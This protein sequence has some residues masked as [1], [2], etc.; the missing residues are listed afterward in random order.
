M[1]IN[2][3]SWPDV[4]LTSSDENAKRIHEKDWSD[5]PLGPIEKWSQSFVTILTT[6]MSSQFPALMLWGPD[7]ITFYNAGYATVLGEKQL[8]ALGKPLKEVWPE[9]WES[10]YGMLKGVIATGIGSW[11]ED[12]IY[13]LHRNGFSEESYFTFSFARIIDE[14]G[15][16]GGILCT[17]IETT[18][19]V[20][21]E[22]R[23]K[24]LREIGNQAGAKPTVEEVY[25]ESLSVIKQQTRDIPFAVLMI[26]SAD[27]LTAN[28]CCSSGLENPNQNI[29]FSE[30]NS[31]NIFKQVCK[32]ARSQFLAQLPSDIKQL[33]SGYELDPVSS[34]LV[35]PIKTSSGVVGL[36]LV[37]LSS[38]LP[39][40][41]SYRSFLDLV[42]G[43][44]SSAVASAKVQ[45]DARDR[46]KALAELDQLK[47]TFFSN[48]SHEFRT[49][50]TLILGPLEDLLAQTKGTEISIGRETFESIYRNS[51]RL[52]KLV[53]SL[54]DFSRMEA[55][56]VEASFE[57]VNLA[58]FTRDLAS[59]FTSVMQKGNL[60]LK[61]NSEVL[62]ESIFIDVEMWEK[63][64]LNLLSNAF[65]FTFQ[66]SVQ[67]FLKNLPDGVELS[68][69]DSGIGISKEELPKIF[70]RYHRVEGAK[71]RSF[72]GSG[73]GLAIVQEMV[74]VHRGKIM[75]ESTEGKGT[76]FRVFIPKGYA[77]LPLDQIKVER[78]SESTRLKADAFIDEASRWVPEPVII[79]IPSETRST[80]LIVDDNADMREYLSHMLDQNYNVIV[81][82]NGREA[83]NVVKSRRP[84]LVIS[85]IMMPEMDGF[86][87]LR[88]LKRKK[89]TNSLPV[90]FLSARAGNEAT[91]EGLEAGADDYLV[92]PFSS[93]ELIARVQ[94]QLSMVKLRSDLEHER[95]A[96]VARDEFL[97]IA[98]H[99]LN[100]P[101]T[102]LKLQVQS[103][104]RALE[105]NDLSA[106]APEKMKNIVNLLNRQID[107][108]SKLIRN[109]LDVTHISQGTMLLHKQKTDLNMIISQ[110]FEE[111]NNEITDSGCAV[112]LDLK[113]NIPLNMDAVRIQQVITNLLTNALKYAGGK[114]VRISSF[115][116]DNTA[117]L[118]VEDNGPGISKENLEII[119]NR[120]ERINASSNLGG[121]GLG[122][123]ISKQIVESHGGELKVESILGKGSKFLIGLPI[124]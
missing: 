110:V 87:L 36:L 122:L 41:E 2:K 57:P 73:I 17:A 106:I 28:V 89:R 24:T 44:I 108:M 66:G 83:L 97:S 91:V 63:I 4:L 13:Y 61:V 105:K 29:H 124:N 80:I 107:K 7:F 82:V 6:S 68:V 59:Q 64:V 74:K 95:K 47:N 98:S 19:K 26:L 78:K 116:Q 101:L 90:I 33:Q 121:L 67:V 50:L 113:E 52:L 104:T 75:V 118:L 79:N 76:I 21:G 37:G 16:F 103:L 9:A 92:K 102:P 12:Q 11:A 86:E 45:V 18:Q 1:S 93:K 20:I 56:R 5:N 77:H 112:T 55:G 27:G 39:F 32:S 117:I 94:T 99:E 81:A 15:G 109:M 8:W 85:D 119:F 65:K 115:A 114:P 49:P 96:L 14:R 53:N 34:A 120:Y 71:S 22:R 84:D 42:A 30:N 51:L 40:D 46:A 62:S 60:N 123:Y 31:R 35:L 23:L 54:L 100:T 88:E 58:N 48:V 43:Q 25:E 38:H 10:L 69:Q 111:H 72:E 70:N 3:N